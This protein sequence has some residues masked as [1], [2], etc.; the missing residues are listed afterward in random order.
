MLGGASGTGKSSISSSLAS[1]LGL[2]EVLSTDS[3]RHI[4][5]N[6]IDKKE[7]PFL[8]VSTYESHLT[9]ADSEV[10]SELRENE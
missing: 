2:P 3:I 7:Y 5:R 6:F 10:E 4:L 9:V 1:H 8:F